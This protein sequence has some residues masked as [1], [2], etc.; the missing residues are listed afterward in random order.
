MVRQFRG[1]PIVVLISLAVIATACS[2]S[3][4]TEDAEAIVAAYV[5]SVEAISADN[6]ETIAEAFESAFAGTEG[7]SFEALL[8]EFS[9]A[10]EVAIAAD[11]DSLVRFEALDPP[12]LFVADHERFIVFVMD[13]IGAVTRQRAAADAGDTE[14]IAQ[15]DIEVASMVRGA[16]AD[17]SPAFGRHVARSANAVA[18]AALFAGLTAEE[19]DYFDDV[20]TGWDEFGRRNRAFSQALSRSYTSDELLLLALL[21]AG[22]GEAFAAAQAVMVQIDPPP[23]YVDGHA[24]LLALFDELVALDAE[25]AEAARNGDVVGFE[26]ANYAIRVAQSRFI[27]E[28]PPSLVAV[29]GPTELLVPPEDLAGGAY[30]QAL[31]EALQRFDILAFDQT[32]SSGV[33]P[34]VSDEKLAQAMAEVMPTAIEF[35]EQAVA[36]VDALAPPAEFEAGHDRVL[37]Y[38]GGLVE[39]RQSILQAATTGDLEALRTYGELGS[40]QAERYETELFCAARAD[41]A[42]DPIEPITATLFSLGGIAATEICP[43]P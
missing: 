15:I 20:A 39:L 23:S 22:A 10:L 43:A 24:Q 37:A 21:D 9:S 27:L 8:P 16:L 42:D 32:I 19:T 5:A 11:R 41:L 7:Q 34:V 25:I 36:S 38:L 33:F 12:E 2:G 13:Q 4:S 17:L 35:T 6:E 1:G 18:D 14:L 30:G 28:A 40:F 31:W 3:G 26:V 29:N